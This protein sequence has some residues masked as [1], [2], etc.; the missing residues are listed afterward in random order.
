MNA[1]KKWNRRVRMT[2][3]LPYFLAGGIMT[4]C[5]TDVRDA[6]ISGGLDFV[7]G[8]ITSVLGAAIPIGPIV[9]RLLEMAM[10]GMGS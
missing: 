10:S 3:W 9:E 1:R 2:R 7:T 5:A 4:S 8:T 6:V